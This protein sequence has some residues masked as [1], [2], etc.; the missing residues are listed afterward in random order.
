MPGTEV[1][2]LLVYIL[3]LG[4]T[5]FPIW[6]EDFHIFQMTGKWRWEWLSQG[7]HPWRVQSPHYC[8]GHTWLSCC[9][10]IEDMPLKFNVGSGNNIKKPWTHEAF[11]RSFWLDLLQKSGELA[12]DPN[13]HVFWMHLKQRQCVWTK[14]MGQRVLMVFKKCSARSV[15]GVQQLGNKPLPSCYPFLV[16]FSALNY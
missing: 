3:Y 2:S 9:C 13:C 14:I 12:C 11:F 1:S 7:W 8:N 5:C 4:V 15:I 16:E 10:L 6:V